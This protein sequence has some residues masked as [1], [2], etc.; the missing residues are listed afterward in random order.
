LAT[1]KEPGLKD[2]DPELCISRQARENIDKWRMEAS[3]PTG[4]YWKHGYSF[5]VREDDTDFEERMAS[6][7]GPPRSLLKAFRTTRALS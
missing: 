1:L 2:F 4:V 3:I 5:M 7:E 6:S